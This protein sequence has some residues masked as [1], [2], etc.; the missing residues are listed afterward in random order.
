MQSKL[1]VKKVNKE[2]PVN[3]LQGLN[4]DTPDPVGG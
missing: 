1:F 3:E 2:N 4:Q